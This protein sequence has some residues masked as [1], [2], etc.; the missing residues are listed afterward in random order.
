[1][2][3]FS[4]TYTLRPELGI[5]NT[6]MM[7]FPSGN[8]DDDLEVEFEKGGV[9]EAA[10]CP[11]SSVSQLATMSKALVVEVVLKRTIDHT[12]DNLTREKK[13]D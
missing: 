8:A 6:R 4:K 1:M 11:S 5:V 2:T 3:L 9:A 12:V 13:V 7:A 10:N